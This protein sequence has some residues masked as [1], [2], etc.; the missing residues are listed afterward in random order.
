MTREEL[1]VSLKRLVP[2]AERDAIDTP[3]SSPVYQAAVAGLAAVSERRIRRSEASYLL[4]HSLQLGPPASFARPAQLLLELTRSGSLDNALI[5][6]PRKMLVVGPSGRVYSNVDPIEYSRRDESADRSVL[7]ECIVPGEV[8]NLDFLVSDDINALAGKPLGTFRE[9]H[10]SLA[11]QSRGRVN[12]GAS[13]VFLEGSTTIKD[14]GIPATFEAGD[15]G[16]YAEI[17]FSATMANIGKR[18]RIRE[19]RWPGIEEP[20]GSNIRPTYAVLDDQNVPELL[21]AAFQDDGGVFT[22]YTQQANNQDAGDV[23]ILPA[24]P[25]VGDA[26]YFGATATINAINILT[27]T[28]ADG[29]FELAW[30]IW[31]GAAWVVPEGLLD[32]TVSFTATGG[33]RV[34]IITHQAPTTV[35]GVL[36]YWV[37]V[38]VAAFTSIVTSPVASYVV[39]LCVLPLPLEEGTVEWAVRDWKDLGMSITAAKHFSLGRDN[40]LGLLGDNRGMYPQTGETEESFRARIARIPDVISPN[41]LTRVVNRVLAPLRKTGRVIDIGDEVKGFFFDVD[42]LDYYETGDIYPT[43]KW[44]L[45]LSIWEAY[46]F[47]Y[48]QVPLVADGD[49]GMFYDEGPLLYL[50]AKGLYIGPAYDEGFY[51]GFSP[52]GSQQI[53]KLIYEE[54]LRRKAG[55]IDFAIL[56]DPTLNTAP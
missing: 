31:D 54:V 3:N 55:G 38:R 52:V 29:V 6:E 22:D 19:H 9:E 21:L 25:V 8:G 10:L 16:L 49:F 7:F 18:Y 42:A 50:S 12:T 35:N 37:R 56:P 48:V 46:G 5:V 39:P 4:P 1:L 27:A 28:A 20:P 30:E 40:D 45:L 44:K 17:L 43:N 41:A 36:A 33:K 26:F 13:I 2:E 53:Y 23:P 24:V 15:R 34:E 11:D 51:D 32:N 47:F 14:S